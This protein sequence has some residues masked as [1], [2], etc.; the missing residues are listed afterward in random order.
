MRLVG[1]WTD[2]RYNNVPAGVCDLAVSKM[3]VKFVYC[4]FLS[5]L[6]QAQIFNCTHSA[7]LKKEKKKTFDHMS[8]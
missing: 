8:I 3:Y 4:P 1:V 7:C 5:L 2:H 6:I